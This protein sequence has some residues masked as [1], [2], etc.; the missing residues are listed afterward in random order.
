MK[1]KR[2]KEFSEVSAEIRALAQGLNAIFDR[3]YALVKPLIDDVCKHPEN[4]GRD[5]LENLFDA[6]LDIMTTKGDRLFKRL[7]KAF[8]PYYP[9][10]VNDYIRIKEEQP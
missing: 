2:A 7:C 1:R 9:D 10:S 4:V 3:S 6:T 8:A 5:E